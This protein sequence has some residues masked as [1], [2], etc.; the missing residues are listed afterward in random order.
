MAACSTVSGNRRG[1]LQLT[2]AGCGSHPECAKDSEQV[3][4][5][6]RTQGHLG[7]TELHCCAPRRI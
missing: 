2:G 3:C 7:L 1:V 6:R 5:D 4:L